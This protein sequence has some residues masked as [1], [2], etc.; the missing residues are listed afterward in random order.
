M[1]NHFGNNF[2]VAPTPCVSA[3]EQHTHP[4]QLRLNIGRPLHLV[5][6]ILELV[7][8]HRHGP[9][10]DLLTFTIESRIQ[11]LLDNG[12][13]L[14]VHLCLTVPFVCSSNICWCG[15]VR[16][17]LLLLRFTARL[18]QLIPLGLCIEIGIVLK[19]MQLPELSITGLIF[20][21]QQITTFNNFHR[22]Q[23]L[24]SLPIPIRRIPTPNTINPQYSSIESSI[25]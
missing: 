16:F 22:N 24:K 3:V 11:L 1:F 17:R 2:F 25:I 20:R 10:I 15:K 14:K 13:K 4:I 23:C 21:N 18:G 8:Q 6:M 9:T 5:H 19:D 7:C 12:I